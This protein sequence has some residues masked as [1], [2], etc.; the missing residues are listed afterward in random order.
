LI[1]TP[2]TLQ[3]KIEQLFTQTEF[4]APDREVFNDFKTELRQGEIRAAENVSDLISLA[5]H[6]AV[7]FRLRSNPNLIRQAETNLQNW[8]SINPNT[9]AWLEWQMILEDESF[10]NIL[11]IITAETDEGQRLRSSSPF[12]G[13]VTKEERRAIIEYCEKAKSS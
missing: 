1:K 11:K 8:L 4:D 13:L 9:R 6:R 3:E 12:A 2:M 5:L 10:E 7:A